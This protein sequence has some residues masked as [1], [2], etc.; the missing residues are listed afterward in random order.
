[1]LSIKNLAYD[2]NNGLREEEVHYHRACHVTEDHGEKWSAAI[3]HATE[4]R[5]HGGLMDRA[6]SL[7]V[8]SIRGPTKRNSVIPIQITEQVVKIID[9]RRPRQGG[10]TARRDILIL[11][12]LGSDL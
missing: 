10:G 5:I 8:Y 2:V 9:G 1:M 12:H 7:E 3:R 4:G 11:P 6:R